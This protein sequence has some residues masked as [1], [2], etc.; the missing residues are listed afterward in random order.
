M[1]CPIHGTRL[2]LKE[3]RHWCEILECK[4]RG[5]NART[6]PVNV[7]YYNEG[8]QVEVWLDGD[9]GEDDEEEENSV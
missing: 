3:R 2:V 5:R 9:C 7:F 4:P 8:V 1:L 6:H